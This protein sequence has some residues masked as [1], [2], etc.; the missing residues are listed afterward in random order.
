LVMHYQFVELWILA[1]ERDPLTKFF[2]AQVFG[3]RDLCPLLLFL[4]P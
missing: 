3:D 4:W 2:D 1:G